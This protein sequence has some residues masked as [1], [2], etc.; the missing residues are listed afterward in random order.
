MKQ[1]V[2]TLSFRRLPLNRAASISLLASEMRILLSKRTFFF[3]RIPW[4]VPFGAHSLLNF[5]RVALK[6]RVVRKAAGCP[7]NR[8]PEPFFPPLLKPR[9][10][11]DSEAFAGSLCFGGNGDSRLAR[12]YF[13]GHV[14]GQPV[15]GGYIYGLCNNHALSIAQTGRNENGA[16]FKRKSLGRGR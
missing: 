6:S 10:P 11:G 5:R 15:A 3:I 13:P 16:V 9:D 8:P 1:R 7:Y 12:G 4:P 2:F 14:N